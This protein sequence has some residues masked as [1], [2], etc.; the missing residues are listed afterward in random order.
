MFYRDYKLTKL[1]VWIKLFT[2][3]FYS[4]F[5]IRSDHKKLQWHCPVSQWTWVL[6]EGP[7]LQKPHFSKPS[8]KALRHIDMQMWAGLPEPGRSNHTSCSRSIRG[9]CIAQRPNALEQPHLKWSRKAAA[10]CLTPVQIQMSACP[11]REAVCLFW[12]HRRTVG[13]VSIESHSAFL[14]EGPPAFWWEVTT[15]C[16][17]N[18]SGGKCSSKWP[19]VQKAAGL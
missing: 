15:G 6:P 8:G 16:R 10:L 14:A 17:C 2:T 3:L 1:N 18:Y 5:Q 4:R 7:F 19:C 11:W 9:G 12:F 13:V